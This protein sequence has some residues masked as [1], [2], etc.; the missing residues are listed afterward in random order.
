ML[1]AMQLSDIP[2]GQLSTASVL[3]CWHVNVIRILVE[4]SELSQ[5]QMVKVTAIH[6]FIHCIMHLSA[7][8]V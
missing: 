2:P 4:A 5:K 6:S 8:F 7:Q 1:I 3:G